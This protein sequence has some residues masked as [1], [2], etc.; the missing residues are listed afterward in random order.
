MLSIAG[1]LVGESQTERRLLAA[2]LICVLISIEVR[3]NS[4][5]LT[6]SIMQKSA[7]YCW[8]S[9]GYDGRLPDNEQ[10]QIYKY[11]LKFLLPKC[12]DFFDFRQRVLWS[13]GSQF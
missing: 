12:P 13:V 1:I 2:K 11:V 5:T 10:E 9:V 7:G 3:L 8:K 6:M 4:M